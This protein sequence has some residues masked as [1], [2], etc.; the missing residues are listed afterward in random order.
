MMVLLLLFWSVSLAVKQVIFDLGKVLLDY[1]F[2]IS[3]NKLNISRPDNDLNES[4][5]LIRSFNS[6]EITSLELYKIVLN[7]FQ[8]DINFAE[9]VDIWCDIF[10]ENPEMINLAREVHHKHRTFIFSNTDELHFPY[11]WKKFP[12]LN[13]FGNNLM[14]SYKLGAVKPEEESYQRALAEFSLKPEDCLFIDDKLDNIIAAEKSGIRGIHHLDFDSTKLK[15][16][17]VLEI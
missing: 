13:F 15:L 7:K 4:A 3:Y 11:I 9:F 2:N 17:E 16:S 6:G 10:Q 1:D 5:E 14:L 12:A 8:L